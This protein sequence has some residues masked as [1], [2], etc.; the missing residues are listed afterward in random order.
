[1]A[2]LKQGIY[3]STK[4]NTLVVAEDGRN[5]YALYDEKNKQTPFGK[6]EKWPWKYAK[7][8]DFVKGQGL[9]RIGDF[10]GL[11]F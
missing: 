6:R 1:M 5:L 4:G 10:N 3:K 9:V 2:A 11:F 7:F 8:D